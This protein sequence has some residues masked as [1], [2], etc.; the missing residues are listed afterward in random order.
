MRAQVERL[1]G[2]H[3]YPL[4]YAGARVE[5]TELLPLA[6]T[7]ICKAPDFPAEYRGAPGATQSAYCTAI[8]VVFEFRFAV[9]IMTGTAFPGVTPVGSSTFT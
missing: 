1:A 9:V 4:R 3:G 2:Q 8:I 6:R 5:C 7:S